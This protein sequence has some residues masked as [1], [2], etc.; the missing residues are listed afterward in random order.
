LLTCTLLDAVVGFFTDLKEMSSER[1]R[2]KLAKLAEENRQ[3]QQAQQAAEHE[4]QQ[5]EAHI[6][7]GKYHLSRL[8]SRQVFLSIPELVP[9]AERHLDRAEEEFAE[10]AFAP[11]WGEIERATNKLA[12][13]QQRIQTINRNALEYQRKTAELPRAIA[14]NEPP[15]ALPTGELSDARPTTTRLAAIVRKAQKNFQFATIYEQRKTNQN[16]SRRIRHA[17]VGYLRSR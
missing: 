2:T 15:F 9:A 5:Q 7:R 12:D 6:A 8:L 1:R 10:G 14:R 17:R 13:Y 4:R 16:L 11:F 3:R